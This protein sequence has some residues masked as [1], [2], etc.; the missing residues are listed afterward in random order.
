MEIVEIKR[1]VNEFSIAQLEAAEDA[2]I[3][4]IPMEI[5]VGGIDEGERLTHVIAAKYIKQDMELNEVTI[6]KAV[7]NYTLKVRSSIGL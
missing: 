4:E 7:R 3:N 2:I 6:G 1:L 5:E